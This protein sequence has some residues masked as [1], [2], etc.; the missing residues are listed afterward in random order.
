MT[1]HLPQL[2][3]HFPV[4]RHLEVQGLQGRVRGE[5]AQQPRV[6]MGALLRT[7]FR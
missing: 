1:F 4:V 3:E 2:V 7:V 6:Q 5:V